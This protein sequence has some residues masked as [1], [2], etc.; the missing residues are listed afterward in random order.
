M[1]DFQD[2]RKPPKNA[3]ATIAPRINPSKHLDVVLLELGALKALF[4]VMAEGMDGSEDPEK[5]AWC[6]VLFSWG[7]TVERC[8]HDLDAFWEQHRRVICKSG[9]TND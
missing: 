4:N 8:M 9:A 7:R 2:T 5:R 3:A 6:S 1:A